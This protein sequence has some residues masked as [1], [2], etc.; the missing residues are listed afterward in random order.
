MEAPEVHTTH[1]IIIAAAILAVGVSGATA[2][3]VVVDPTAPDTAATSAWDGFYAGVFGGYAAGTMVTTDPILHSF[4]RPL[5][6]SG[7]L[8]G[9]QT[10]Y[11]F[12]LGGPLVGGISVDMAYNNGYASDD[13]YTPD[14]MW[15]GSATARVGVDIYNVVPYLVGGVAFARA[16]NTD[17]HPITVTQTHI[18][19]T[20]GTGIEFALAD[21][22]SA[23]VEV[24]HTDYGQ[25]TY[26]LANRTDETLA[27]NSVRVGV[28]Y[29][30]N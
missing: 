27:D 21:N 20:I 10:G 8:L 7:Y 25:K 14:F 9:V 1:K 26:Q 23:N 3:G 24:R 15:S 5:D 19:Y 17:R 11:N 22:V 18:G 16:S 4:N 12:T 2:A 13:S 30:F 6:Y 29:H 28:N